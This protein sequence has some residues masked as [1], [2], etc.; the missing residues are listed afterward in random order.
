MDGRVA[1]G[2]LGCW[3]K[4]EGTRGSQEE[5]RLYSYLVGNHDGNGPIESPNE[6]Y[7]GQGITTCMTK[8]QS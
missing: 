5:E 3:S 2:Y 7:G 6:L 8:G 1:S 4:R